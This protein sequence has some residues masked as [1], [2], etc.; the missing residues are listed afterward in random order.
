M[1]AVIQGLLISEKL[2][3]GRDLNSHIGIIIIS[4]KQHSDI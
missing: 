4:M 3:I 1:D 2:I